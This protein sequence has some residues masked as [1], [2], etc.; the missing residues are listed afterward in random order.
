MH[1]LSWVDEVMMWLKGTSE[2]SRKG[3]YLWQKTMSIILRIIVSIICIYLSIGLSVFV[4]DL[5]YMFVIPAIFGLISLILTI[6]SWEIFGVLGMAFDFIVDSL[7]LDFFTA[8]LCGLSALFV[9]CYYSVKYTRF[10]ENFPFWLDGKFIKAMLI[11]SLVSIFL[12]ISFGDVDLDEGILTFLTFGAIF[13]SL[14][15]NQWRIPVF[16]TAVFFAIPFVFLPTM[17]SMGIIAKNNVEIIQPQANY[18]TSNIA[19]SSNI[20]K[21]NPLSFN[22]T[23]GPNLND[24]LPFLPSKDVKI[25]FNFRGFKAKGKA[26]RANPKLKSLAK[27]TKAMSRFKLTNVV[28]NLTIK[29]PRLVGKAIKPIGKHVAKLAKP[30]RVRVK[31]A[32]QYYAQRKARA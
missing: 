24:Y 25:R 21:N 7:F 22:V 17:H 19:Y 27:A 1:S 26:S 10:I 16:F 4:F 15:S 32:K 2:A 18:K 14:F 5:A 3:N 28:K 20:F 31:K 29:L 13:F 12:F 11:S 23:L 30:V 6:V 9:L 8:C